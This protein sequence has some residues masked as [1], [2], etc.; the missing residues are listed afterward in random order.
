[1]VDAGITTAALTLLHQQY[2]GDE[3]CT[4]TMNNWERGRQEILD[5]VAK[6]YDKIR[7]DV[8]TGKNGPSIFWLR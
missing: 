7:A 4:I 6:I 2:N 5:G 8:E 3:R 1:M